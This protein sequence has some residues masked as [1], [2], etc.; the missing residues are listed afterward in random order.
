MTRADRS[1]PVGLRI[2]VA[3]LALLALLWYVPGSAA[4]APSGSQVSDA[5]QAYQAALSKLSAIRSEVAAIQSQLNAAVQR[6]DAQQQLVDQ[7]TAQVIATQKRIESAEEKYRQIRSRLSAR[8][9]ESFMDGPGSNLGFILGST[10][11][12]DLSDRL[13][14]VNAV[15]DSDAGLAQ[16]VDNL[17]TALLADEAQLEKLQA[18]RRERLVALKA[19]QDSIA[20]SL[21][22]VSDLQVEAAHTVESTLSQYRNLKASYAKYLQQAAGGTQ[23]GGHHSPV[24][25]PARYEHI[26]KVCPVA[27]PRYFGDGFGAP[28]YAG[29]YHLHAGVDVVAAKGQPIL[30]PFDGVAHSSY[31]TLG[32]NAVYVEGAEGYVYNAHVD[33]YSALANGPVHA[34]D[35]IAYVGDT[36]DALGGTPHDHFEFHPYFA[37]PP[38]WPISYYGYRVIGTALNPYPLLVAA[39]G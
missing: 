12:A 27:A 2:L 26:L 7:V 34:G 15:T 8:A 5:K 37:V 25:L 9:V 11:L 35:V 21:R 36:G 18:Q 4:G 6:V 10:S 23:V 20:A 1:F 33:H 3:G 19:T 14:F 24:P 31:N 38:D 16:Q 28:R 32:G 30:A 13:E 29:G 17:R 39:C 22:R